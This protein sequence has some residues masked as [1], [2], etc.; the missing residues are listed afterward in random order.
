MP[1]TKSAEKRVRQTKIRTARN[2]R[3]KSIVKTS[4]RR[5]EEAVQAGDM[6]TAKAKMVAAASLID[7]AAAK[8]V[9]HKNNAARKKSRLA[10]ILNR[11][12]A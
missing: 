7:K 3:I 8:G 10:R 4:I 6:D 2:R 11:A 9:I 5:F 1:N 12:L